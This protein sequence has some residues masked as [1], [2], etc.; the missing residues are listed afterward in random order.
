MPGQALSLSQGSVAC[1]KS[2]FKRHINFCRRFYVLAEFHLAFPTTI[3]LTPQA[4]ES[5]CSA[6]PT[7]TCNCPLESGW[8]LSN[9]MSPFKRGPGD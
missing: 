8:A 1:N 3:A 7:G 2:F 5:M 4:Q 6:Y 9:Q